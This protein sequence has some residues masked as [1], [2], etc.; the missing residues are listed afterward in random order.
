M[1]VTPTYPGVYVQEV[2][3]GVRTIAGVSTSVAVYVGRTKKGPLGKPIRCLSYLDFERAFG[4]DTV[5]GDL[6]RAVKLF[7]QNGGTDC[8]V[9]RIANGATYSDV[10]LE[11]EDST[12][13]TP[14]PSLTLT[15]R[16]A[17]PDGE[18]LRAVVTYAGPQP[19]ITFNLDLFQWEI[20]PNGIAQQVGL[21]SFGNLTM[22]PGSSRYAPTFLSQNSKLVTATEA[23]GAPSAG[24]GYSQS[25]RPV[26]YEVASAATFQAAWDGLIGANGTGKG[27]QISV[28]GNPYVEVDL[29][30]IDVSA[31]PTG[32]LMA[33]DLPDAIQTAIQSAYA[34]AG[35]A[36]VVTAVSFEAGPSPLSSFGSSDATA[37]L[38]ITSSTGGNILI[39]SS[40]RPGDAALP[41]ML[42]TPQGG[43]EVGAHAARRPAAS[44]VVLR[45]S[46]LNGLAG[47]AQQNVDQLRLEGF[48]ADGTPTDITFSLNGAA[49]TSGG[50]DPVWVDNKSGSVT[51]NSDG[52]REKLAAV[53]DR[54]NEYASANAK[55]FKWKAELWGNRLAILPKYGDDNII[56]S[57]FSFFEGDG[58]TPVTGWNNAFVPNVRRYSLG[59]AGNN[60]GLQQSAA[61][62][63]SDGS[64]PLA[65]DYDAAYQTI[66][67]EVDL[68]NL[69][70]LPPD[71]DPSAPVPQDLYGAASVFCQSRRAFLIMD[72][73]TDWTTAQ[74]ASEGID[75]LRIGLVKDYSA[76]YY[77]R[78]VMNE[79]G[80]EI[81][82]GAAGAI[83]GLFARTDSQRGVWKAPAGTEADLRGIVGLEYMLNDAENGLLNPR[84]INT[85]RV[86]PVGIVNWG[87]RTMDGDNDFASEWKYVPVRRLALYIEE[88][89]FRGLKW[90]V[91]E[92]NDEPTWAQIRLNVGAFMHNLFRQGA[93]EGSKPSD[94]YFVKCDSE[95]TTATDRNLG[96]VN[97]H[98]GFAPLK[99]AEFVVLSIQ[100]M[101]GQSQV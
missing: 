67:K 25:G 30:G 46:Q 42:G 55:T 86:F 48:A 79:N 19:D 1:P 92:P 56:S 45:A 94:A 78:I 51:N 10:T 89:L 47:T 72:P 14:V 17:G 76:V 73:P 82:V 22:D 100:Q 44:G 16:N 54:I 32:T 57:S 63:A 71:S 49:T 66:D 81:T 28:D 27:F 52:V 83:A 24:N 84:A 31:L 60:V 40:S 26:P 90:V 58:T 15:A 21:E 88:S 20:L 65:T 97:I 41:L 4:T 33:T 2:P 13:G 53:R 64:A 68:F 101:A 74:G 50:A 96:V 18:Y 95:T 70:I 9:L 75:D 99:P 23:A 85:L 11:T 34:S 12:S 77:P 6:P 5:N 37:L 38:R 91:F 80:R 35:I 43:L 69:M 98:V 87:A 7:F 59:T 39:R 62:P 93:F 3:S 61:A 29:S 8:Y 36:G